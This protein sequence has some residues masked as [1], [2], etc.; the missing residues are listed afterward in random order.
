MTRKPKLMAE[1]AAAIGLDEATLVER[2]LQITRRRDQRTIL[3]LK[4]FAAKFGVRL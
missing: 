2:L 1:V 3:A 4:A